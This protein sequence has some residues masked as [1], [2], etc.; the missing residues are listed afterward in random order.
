MIGRARP[1]R[2]QFS[3]RGMPFLTASIL[4]VVLAAPAFAAQTITGVTANAA[5][6]QLTI[7]LVTADKGPLQPKA[8]EL[9]DPKRLV[10]DLPGACLAKDLAASLPAT[11]PGIKQVRL[12]QFSADPAIA[13]IVLDL[14][15]EETPR[16]QVRRGEKAG[17]T[18]IVIQAAGSVE[19]GIPSLKTEGGCVLLR[20]PGAGKLKRSVG[21]LDE[22]YRV[23]ADL[24]NAS[25]DWYKADC[26]QAPL[27]AIR[28]GP[29]EPR[30]GQPVARIV[31]ELREKQAQTVFADGTDL[32][33]AVGPQPWALPLPGYDAA[34]RL[35]GKT[36]VVDPGHGGKDI[37]APAVSGSPPSEP[38]EK[39][40]VLEIGQRLAGLLKAEGASVTMTREDDTYVALQERAAI[41]NK[42]R[43]DALVSIH[44]NSCETPNTLCGTSVYYDHPHSAQFAALV[45]S[46]LVAALGTSDKGVRNANFA[47]IRRTTG[48]GVLVETA[49]I[50]H[51]E[52]RQRLLNPNA[53]E[54]TAR[55]IVQGLLEY[56]RDAAA[57]KKEAA[58]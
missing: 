49:F 12:G 57:P 23:Y 44:C 20:L 32:V 8:F 21:V 29:Q 55:A 34:G 37:G 19:L 50:N 47:V 25:V 28:M 42:L 38:Y 10:F 52:D 40:V 45:Q 48:P 22:P 15:G 36:I 56:L 13:R 7:L 26:D 4:V 17:E 5:A 58:E 9:T 54:R 43:A 27:R 30:D 24:E 16:W 41:A 1:N 53:Q 31:L 14:T 18:L 33:I 2:A 35:K 3:R 6:G 46:E 39:N 11:L 51:D